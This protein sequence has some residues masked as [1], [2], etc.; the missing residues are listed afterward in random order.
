M[1]APKG[2]V[3]VYTISRTL[4]IPTANLGLISNHYLIILSERDGPMALFNFRGGMTLIA[5]S[6][7]L[8]NVSQWRDRVMCAGAPTEEQVRELIP[9]LLLLL[10]QWI[11]DRSHSGMT[12]EERCRHEVIIDRL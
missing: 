11:S 3:G 8:N 2:G 7:S 1:L 12:D 10:L 9:Q 4:C 5:L 6:F